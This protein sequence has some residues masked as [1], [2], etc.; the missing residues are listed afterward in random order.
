MQ[1]TIEVQG[2]TKR[3]GRV[4]AV[5]DLS[6][7]VRPGEVTGFIGPNGAGK[8]TTIRLTMG[9]DFPQAGTGTGAGRRYGALAGPLTTIGPLL[10][11][12]AVHPG[13]TARNHLRW[14]AHS[15]GIASGRV[16][17]VLAQVGLERV[18]RRRV[19]GF[20]LGMRQRLG[21][22][23]ALLGDPAILMLDEPVNGLDPEGIVWIRG[24]LR[25]LAA[26]GRA[27]LVSSHLMTELQDTA[28][29]LLIVEWT[30]LWTVRRWTLALLAAVLSS[31]LFALLAANG[32]STQ[33]NDPNQLVG[34]RG[35]VVQDYFRCV[36]QPL[37]GDGSIV[38]RITS[39]DPSSPWAAAGIMVKTSTTPGSSY[40]ALTVTP[41]HGLR[42]GANFDTDIAA[43]PP[44]TPVRLRLTRPAARSPPAARTT[45]P[46]GTPSA[47]YGWSHPLPPYRWACTSPHHPRRRSRRRSAR[48]RPT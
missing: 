28:D 48:P 1:S 20:S 38:A 16:D 34:P 40:A 8:S 27:V 25:D 18:A 7:T 26:Q 9:L 46:P 41:G 39:Q 33:A 12:G 23:A 3:F 10:D 5:D 29:H 36:H 35:L 31:T 21:I 14:L 15:N 24:L 30:K 13:R 6:S 45:A 2:L 42:L 44:T 11:A 19:G 4:G 22:A 47:P 43:G 32:N 17:A 37:D